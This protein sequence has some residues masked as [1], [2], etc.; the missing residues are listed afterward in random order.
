M[1]GSG[2][3][4]KTSGVFEFKPTYLPKNKSVEQVRR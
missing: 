4:G 2:G 1:I 3:F